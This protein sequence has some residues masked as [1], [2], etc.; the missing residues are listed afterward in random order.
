MATIVR[1]KKT[2]TEY[3]LLGSGYGAY[4]TARPGFWGGDLFPTEEEGAI[5]A[6]MLCD[7]K[8]ELAWVSLET[9]GDKISQAPAVSQPRGLFCVLLGRSNLT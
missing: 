5:R 6:V 1:H 4:K 9:A 2:G 8:G 7:D 3:V